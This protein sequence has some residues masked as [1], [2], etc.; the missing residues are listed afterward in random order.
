MN[1]NLPDEEQRWKTGQFSWLVNEI[2]HSPRQQPLPNR[3]SLHFQVIF[4]TYIFFL[5]EIH[6]ILAVLSRMLSIHEKNTA[7]NSITI[8]SCKGLTHSVVNI[9]LGK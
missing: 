2:S 6:S 8:H 9:H 4:T 7:D 5:R 3:L 1:G